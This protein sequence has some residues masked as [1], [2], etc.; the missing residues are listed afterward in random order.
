MPEAP[1][2]NLLTDPASKAADLGL[3]LPPVTHA[4]SV[5]LPRW[6]DVIDYEEEHPRIAAALQAGY[7]RFFVHPLVAGLF[8]R[9]AELHARE[10]EGCLVFPSAG[11]AE[12]A[13]AYVRKRTGGPA[14]T[15]SFGKGQLQV[16]VFPET[17]RRTAREFWR[18]CGAVVSSRQAERALAEGNMEDLEPAGKA[19]RQALKA[20]LATLAGVTPEDVFL[21]PSGM[22]AMAAAHQLVIAANPGK[23]TVQLDF[24][25]V[26]VLKVQQEF[27]SGVEFFP[28]ADAAALARV[29]DLAASGGIAAV[30]AEIPSNPL[31]ACVPVDTLAPRLRAAGVPLVLDDTVATVINL[32]ALA[33]ADL[34]TTSLTKAFSGTGDVIAGALTVNPAS[35]WHNHFRKSLAAAEAGHTWLCAEDA[36][37]LEANSRDFADRVLRMNAAAEALTGFLSTHPAV[38]KVWY[39]ESPAQFG[40]MAR[41]ESGRGCLFSFLLRDEKTAAAFYDALEVSKGPS[42][43]TNFTLCCPYTLL[44]HYQELGWA[45]DCGVPRHLLRVS[46]GLE[47]PEELVRRFSAALESATGTAAL[48][49]GT[50]DGK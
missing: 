50:S 9:A 45:A 16:L 10:G 38:E 12:Q 43:G 28:V 25:Y 8:A 13:A 18:Y 47:D 41:K 29:A 37:V 40:R 6:Q 19:A 11:A 36:I 15:V 23:P 34:V 46:A 44:A 1:V 39:P 17:A 35:P 31:L 22:A 30:F 32:D 4:V 27:G 14:R 7:P 20:R 42:L 3:P 26:D 49:A 33:V 5:A 48:A 21:F 24:P 2:R